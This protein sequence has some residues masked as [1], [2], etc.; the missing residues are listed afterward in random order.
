MQIERKLL[1]E[2]AQ[3]H[4]AVE[5]SDLGLPPGRF[6]NTVTTAIGNRQPFLDVGTTEDGGRRYRQVMGCCE[7]TILND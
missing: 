7:I 1:T 5:A 3:F 6:P 2:T 4:F